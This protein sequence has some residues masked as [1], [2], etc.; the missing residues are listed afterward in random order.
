MYYIYLWG[1]QDMNVLLEKVQ[2][3]KE[4]VGEKLQTEKNGNDDGSVNCE[5]KGER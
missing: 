4:K 5:I 3:K 1:I 2:V